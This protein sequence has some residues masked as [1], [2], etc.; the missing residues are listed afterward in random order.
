MLFNIHTIEQFKVYEK[1]TGNIGKE[2][3]KHA[4]L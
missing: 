3:K 1:K 4:D 2:Y